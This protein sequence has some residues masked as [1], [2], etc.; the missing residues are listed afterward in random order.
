MDSRGGCVIAMKGKNCVAMASDLGFNGEQF[1]TGNNTP[2]IFKICGRLFIGLTGLLG[3]ISSVKQI[4]EYEVSNFLV[5]EN[6]FP[7]HFE[8]TNILSHLLYKNRFTPFFVE[9]LFAGMDKNGNPVINSMDIIGA[10]SN[11]IKF[12]VSGSCSDGLFGVCE[13]LWKPNMSKKELFQVICKCI[14]FATNRDCL[15]GWG[16][17]IHVITEK[18]ILSKKIQFRTD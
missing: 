4:L 7:E 17:I 3:D 6:R 16:A 11:S 15:S 5:K 10:I 14:S 12:S 8:I 2:K 13:T 18:E 9:P 1:I